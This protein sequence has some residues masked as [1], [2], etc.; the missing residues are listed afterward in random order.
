MLGRT[1][2]PLSIG[3]PNNTSVQ[4]II[5]KGNWFEISKIPLY[6]RPLNF[7]SLINNYIK[8]NF[9]SKILGKF[10][11]FLHSLLFKKEKEVDDIS[12]ERI[13]EFGEEFDDLW[14]LVRKKI[15]IAVIRDSTYLNWRYIQKPE[16]NYIIFNIKK[17]KE[18]KGYI[19][20]KIAQKFGLKIGLII[21]I[22][23]DPTN[24]LYVN[25]LIN[26]VILYFQKMKTDLISVIMY[27]NH[28]Y[29]KSLKK[30]GFIKVFKKL[31]PQKFYFVAKA[32]NNEVI[33]KFIKNP[34]N[35]YITWGDTD[36]V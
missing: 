24:I 4:V 18:L 6:F 8:N 26:H 1:S 15:K 19:V 35:W 5:N 29:L 3:F 11:N 30:L 12:I 14:N 20:L 25:C 32:N 23:A 34:K 21:D 28:V 27:P 33:E 10:F 9:F 17:N 2:I 16:E 13:F 31:M 7:C 22:L 36:V